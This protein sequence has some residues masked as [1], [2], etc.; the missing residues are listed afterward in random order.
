M[1]AEGEERMHEKKRVEGEK[2][3]VKVMSVKKKGGGKKL[4]GLRGSRDASWAFF[5]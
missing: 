2:T 5:L 4:M 1:C 3:L